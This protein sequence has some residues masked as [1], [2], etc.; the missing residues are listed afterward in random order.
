MMR[1][2]QNSPGQIAA[3]IKQKAA[4]LGFDLVAIARAEPTAR[5]EFITRWLDDGR[6][7][8]MHYLHERLDERL[9]PHRYF[10]AARSIVCLALNY[11]VPLEPTPPH[12]ARLARYAQGDDY[13]DKLKQMLYDLADWVRETFPG[14][15]TRCGTDS[16]PV[17]EREHAAR[18]GIGWVG[19]NTLVI[20]PRIGSWLLLGEVMT[21]LELPPDRPI[22]TDHCGTCTRCIDACPTAAITGP[23][24]LDARK[25]IS[26][27]TIEHSGEIDDALKPKMGDWLFGCDIC[28]DVCPF[29]G[30]APITLTP[31]LQPRRATN[32]ID[33][34]AV[35]HWSLDDYH[36][37]TRRSPMRRV[38]LPI[39]QRNAKIVAAN[40]SDH[41][42]GPEI[43]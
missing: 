41:L 34:N 9:D 33:V 36:V 28:Q 6:A 32:S 35:E 2:V 7:G 38:K 5:R 11:H 3:A 12:H 25:C 40:L 13:H 8:E 43:D 15:E 1:G 30:K 27:L 20:H 14:T 24:Q 21:S 39:L 18:A 22:T 31:W 37:A 16:V 4:Q 19:K 23:R 42:S 10:P 29:N 17:L 26:Y